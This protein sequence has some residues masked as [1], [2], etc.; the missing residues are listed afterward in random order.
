MLKTGS[1]LIFIAGVLWFLAYPAILL[2]GLGVF[3]FPAA[4][5]LGV[6]GLIL[7]T[8]AI[9]KERIKEKESDAKNDYSQY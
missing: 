5:G 9:I 4:I 3:L 6:I 8:M 7:V 1:I 2:K